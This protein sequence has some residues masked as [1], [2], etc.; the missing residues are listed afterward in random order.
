MS[1]REQLPLQ[2]VRDPAP[3]AR[4]RASQIELKGSHTDVRRQFERMDWVI[5]LLFPKGHIFKYV[6]LRGRWL[7]WLRRNAR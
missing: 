2:I 5:E 1:W 3:P 6:T 7:A 4:A